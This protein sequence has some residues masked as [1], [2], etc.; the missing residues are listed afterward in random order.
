MRVFAEN[1]VG[2]GFL[3][4][5]SY[6]KYIPTHEKIIDVGKNGPNTTFNLFFL[7][8]GLALGWGVRRFQNDVYMF[9]NPAEF[10]RS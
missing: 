9:S 2:L 4:S 10:S 6:I 1:L 3:S 5:I 7:G 8:V